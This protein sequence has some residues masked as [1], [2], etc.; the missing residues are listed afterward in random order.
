[1]EKVMHRLLKL[2]A[3]AMAGFLDFATGAL[4]ISL[5]AQIGFGFEV[6]LWYLPIG[7]ILALLP[8]FDIL[9]PIL[10][11]K[12]TR[13]NHH[14]TLMHR[15]SFLMILATVVAWL[16][17]GSLFA[18]TAF[19]CLLWHY[20]HDTWPLG[21]D[22]IDWAWP[23]FERPHR[24]DITPGEWLEKYWLQP[25]KKSVAEIGFGAI[26]LSIALA[27]TGNDLLAKLLPLLVLFG[28]LIVWVANREL[29][30]M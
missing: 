17:G 19:V 4:I 2:G 9:W 23:F 28:V 5:V 7:G 25:S 8:D 18:I 22:H 3:N 1:M 13:G 16:C 12:K 29:K 27:Q 30:R 15:P 10:T 6:L 24:T 26:F 14:T 21:D 11:G 20:L